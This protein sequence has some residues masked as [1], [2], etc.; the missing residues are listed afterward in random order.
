MDA[1][2]FRMALLTIISAFILVAVIIY[3]T[4]TE[5]INSLFGKKEKISEE[6]TAEV[7]A[8]E[9]SIV[10]GEQIGTDL[11]SFLYD[12]SFFDEN[13]KIPAVVVIKKNSKQ[14]DDSGDEVSVPEEQDDNGTGMAVVGQLD[15][16]DAGGSFDSVDVPPLVDPNK[17]VEGTP[18]E[19][20]P[21]G[22]TP[23][24]SAA[25]NP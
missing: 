16:P 3:A 18:V 10:Y 17:P 15:N 7:S 1:K 6:V 19:G 24:G 2:V 23:V 8:E 22:S 13:E 25:S 4:N 11:K 21:V 20:T 14:P 5:K 12:D 9:T